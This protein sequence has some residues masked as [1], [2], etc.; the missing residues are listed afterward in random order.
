LNITIKE[1]ESE[2]KNKRRFS[3]DSPNNGESTE[4]AKYPS[5]HHHQ[6]LILF[7][8]FLNEKVPEGV[9]YRAPVLNIITIDQMKVEFRHLCKTWPKEITESHIK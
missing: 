3:S 7:I 9:S 4:E 8:P 1:E 6:A 2:R 5:H